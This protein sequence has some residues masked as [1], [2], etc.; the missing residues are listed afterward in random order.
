MSR[1]VMSR[2]VIAVT[3]IAFA[4][5][6]SA[7]FGKV[8]V[9]PA[10]QAPHAPSGSGWQCFEAIAPSRYATPPKSK[11]TVH[12][13]RDMAICTKSADSYRKDPAF[14]QVT[15][16]SPRESAFCTATFTNES[17]ASWGCFAALEDCQTEVGGIAGVPGTKQSECSEYK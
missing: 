17:D 9:V 2:S 12:C 8:T 5:V 7:C 4:I 6:L 10:A 3:G 11:H 15:T 1:S 13:Q 16:C 14:E